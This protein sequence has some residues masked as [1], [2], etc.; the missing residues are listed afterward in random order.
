A[1]TPLPRAPPLEELP[2]LVGAQRFSVAAGLDRM[3]QPHTLLV[4][5]DVLDL[6]RDR[7][8]IDLAQLREDVG[9]RLSVD[10][11]T[12]HWRGDPGLELRCQRRLEQL[13]LERGVAGGL[14][15]E[16]IGGGPPGARG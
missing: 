8:A 13:R 14:R 1:P 9:E 10:A 15:A 2:P 4:V 12:E 7:S 5:R 16:R 11:D 3:P 6:V